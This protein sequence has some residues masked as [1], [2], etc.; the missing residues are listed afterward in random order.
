MSRSKEHRFQLAGKER[1]N[2]WQTEGAVGGGGDSAE[3][4][5]ERKKER[6]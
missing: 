3:R 6:K 5:K 2:G 1:E 4:K